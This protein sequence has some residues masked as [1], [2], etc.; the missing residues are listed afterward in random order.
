MIF[1]SSIHLNQDH[2]DPGLPPFHFL[3]SVS[4]HS[5]HF[6]K[7][8]IILE[9]LYT[10]Q[11]AVFF[12][13]TR[14]LVFHSA[15]SIAIQYLYSEAVSVTKLGYLYFSAVSLAVVDYLYSCF[16]IHHHSHPFSA[17]GKTMFIK[18]KKKITESQF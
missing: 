14:L 9:Y 15:V 7:K 5:L 2:Y 1:I 11:S 6:K 3:D 13:L 8:K 4:P 17:T 12:A 10:F 18:Q 16:I